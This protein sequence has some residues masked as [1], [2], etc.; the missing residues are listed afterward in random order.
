MNYSAF[1]NVSLKINKKIILDN[2][3][4]EIPKHKTTIFLGKNGS[5]KTTILRTINLLQKITSGEI[6]SNNQKP[7]PMLFQKPII[8]E[9]NALYNFSILKKIKNYEAN[10]I[11][12]DAFELS[13]THQQ[14]IKKLSGGEKQKL[15]LSRV[16]SVDPEVIIMDE[17]NQN[18][19][20]ESEKTLTQLIIDQK[21][22]NKTIV[23]TLHDYK[24]AKKL[25]DFI[26]LLDKGKILYQGK[27]ELFFD[28]YN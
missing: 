24:L 16:M 2:I 13:L 27:G 8:F 9:G 18:L 19:D 4:F 5:G 26:I 22:R 6:I 25:A 14:D 21:I 1:K 11:W 28:Q 10:L 12:H 23:L 7:I 3:S 17:P 20:L 15:F